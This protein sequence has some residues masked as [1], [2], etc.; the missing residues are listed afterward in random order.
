M[1]DSGNII[2]DPL[3]FIFSA[4]SHVAILRALMDSREGMSGRSAARL[5]G[6]NHQACAMALKKL[7][8]LGI[9][10]RRGA[11]KTQLI[12]LN[13][14]HFLVQETLLPLLRGERRFLA[15]IRQ[16]LG[17]NLGA[18]VLSA[19]LFGSAARGEA[20]LGSDL[21]LLLIVRNATAG[22]QTSDRARDLGEEFIERYGIRFS[23]LVMTLA[24]AKKRARRAEPL[25]SNI[26]S[27]GIDLGPGK[28]KELLS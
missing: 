11:G 14:K 15:Q 17:K 4:P 25:M 1:R 9:V 5:A 26:L 2:A 7:E 3:N 22:A 8:A 13:A 6:V 20:G 19:T 27:E 28:I 16:E 24:E 10:R 18:Q 12:S 23:P 21:D